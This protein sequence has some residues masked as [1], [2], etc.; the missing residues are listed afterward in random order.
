MDEREAAKMFDKLEAVTALADEVAEVA[1][2]AW[3][4][5]DVP[6]DIRYAFS[7]FASDLFYH[8]EGLHN[9]LHNA[10]QVPHIN[11]YCNFHSGS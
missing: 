3:E 8:A 10:H 4:E 1:D 2:E 11:P 9:F 7:K 6:N 5:T